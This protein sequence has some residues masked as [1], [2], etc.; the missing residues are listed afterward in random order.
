MNSSNKISFIYSQKGK[1]M[2]VIDNFVFKLNKTTSSTK[3]YRCSDSC[4]TVIVHTDLE[5]NVLK[6]K[7]DHCRP[8]EPEEVQI[9]TFRQAV[10]ARAINET[11][12]I[13]QIYDEEALR[14][15]LSNLAIAALPSQR[16]ISQ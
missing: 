12:P 10:K 13:P 8:P 4:C 9:R 15:N 1:K 2:L 3:Y 16:E 14:M 7:D 6:I 5:D 11:T